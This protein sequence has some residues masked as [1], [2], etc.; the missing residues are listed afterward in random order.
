MEKQNKHK[1]SGLIITIVILLQVIGTAIFFRNSNRILASNLKQIDSL[2]FEVGQLKDQNQLLHDEIISPN[3][4]NKDLDTPIELPKETAIIDTP[5]IPAIEIETPIQ[6]L[7][8]QQNQLAIAQNQLIEQNKALNNQLNQ[9]QQKIAELQ[10]QNQTTEDLNNLSNHIYSILILGENQKLT[11]TILLAIMNQEKAKITL[12]S[13]PRDLF[14]GGRKINEYMEKYGIEKTEEIIQQITGIKPNKYLQLNFTAFKE[15][16]DSTGGIDIQIDKSFSDDKYPNDSNNG[17]Q[18]VAFTSGME[19]MD[20]SR[21]LQYARS[22]KSTDDFDR[23][24]R[25]QKILIATK[26]K[27]KTM[28]VMNNVQFYIGAFQSLAKNINTDLNILE[29][30]QMFEQTKKYDIA[31]GNILSNENYLYSSTSLTGQSIL[32]PKQSN[33]LS[34]QKKLLEII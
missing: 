28:D 21:A 22:R 10:D 6:Q 1:I 9:K 23:A 25:Q 33:F 34:F 32:L 11:D 2:I 19:K 7:Q 3:L 17:Y 8:T 30:I 4:A 5:A 29:G 15:I 26:E 13:I 24:L 12:L 14:V 31:A 16:I 18:T 27:I 20:G